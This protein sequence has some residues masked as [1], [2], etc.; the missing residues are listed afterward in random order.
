MSESIIHSEGALAT[1]PAKLIGAISSVLTAI[2]AA[3]VVFGVDPERAAA[4]LG[5]VASVLPFIV[6]A[7]I[8]QR[9]YS[10]A[11]VSK[12]VAAGIQHGG[13]IMRRSLEEDDGSGA[14]LA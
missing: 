4:V 6:G 7:V 8:R 2:V 14:H 11:S 10:P 3:L 9:V 5:V 1:E 13:A 12:L